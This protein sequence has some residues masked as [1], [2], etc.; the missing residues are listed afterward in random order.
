M[1]NKIREYIDELFQDAP[2]TKRALEMKEE[3]ISNALEKFMD[4]IKEGYR[5]EDAYGVVIHS[6]G[7]VQ[8]LFEELERAEGPK[9]YYSEWEIQMQKKKAIF[10]AAAVGL[11]IFAGAVFFGFQMVAEFIRWNSEGIETMGLVL[12]ALIC[13]PPTIMLI[14]ASMMVPKYRKEEDTMVEDYKEWKNTS[15]RDKSIRGAIS[16]IIWTLTFILYFVI[17]FTTMAWYIT[18]VIFLIA[19]CAESVVSLLFSMRRS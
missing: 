2:K 6:I 11:Y 13:I 5:E 14:Y 10:T 8:E 4:L 16:S 17:S 7:N 1:N 9:G 18:W 19:A 15:S 3:M 12:A